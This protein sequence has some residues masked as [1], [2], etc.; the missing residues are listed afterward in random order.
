MLKRSHVFTES[1]KA[2]YT[3]LTDDQQVGKM[4]CSICSSPFSVQHGGHS[5]IVQDY[6]EKKT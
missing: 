6:E 5:D 3:Y 1:L 2:E 4:L